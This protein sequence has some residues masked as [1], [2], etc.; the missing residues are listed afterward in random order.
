[1]LPE[2][3]SSRQKATRRKYNTAAPTASFVLHDIS[4][5]DKLFFFQDG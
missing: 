1:M 2:D 3:A 4:I 5:T